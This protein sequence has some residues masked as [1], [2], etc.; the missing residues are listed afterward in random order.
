MQPRKGSRQD[1]ALDS[2]TI[3]P[4]DRTAADRAFVGRLSAEVF[5]R[6]GDYDVM[7]PAIMNRP[8]ART[9]FAEV[10]GQP[11]GFAIYSL[12]GIAECE[13]DLVAIAVVPAWQ[14]RG[15]GQRLL[16]YVESEARRL[17]VR[18]RPIVRLTVAEDNARA[19]TLFERSGYVPI[20]GERGTYPRGQP[21]IG[22]WKKLH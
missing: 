18:D 1:R 3:R 12:E 2:L 9:V 15:V 11:V 8:E 4:V 21:L 7:L 19:R 17:L 20:V 14:S 5:S 13:V 6:F 10:E 16:A 22:L